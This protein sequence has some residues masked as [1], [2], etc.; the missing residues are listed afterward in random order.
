MN[1]QICD[2]SWK[3]SLGLGMILPNLSWL[4]VGIPTTLKNMS[5]LGWWTS[6]LLN[7][8]IKHDPKHQPVSLRADCKGRCNWHTRGIHGSFKKKV[9]LTSP[10]L[11]PWHVRWVLTSPSPGSLEGSRW[12]GR[13]SAIHVKRVILFGSNAKEM[14][15]SSL[16]SSPY[17]VPY[18][19]MLFPVFLGGS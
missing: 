8:K 9:D 7:G 16:I 3:A 12:D 11:K 19:H 2:S 1:K 17:D 10:E 14:C 15:K 18:F 5:Q 4:V 6:Q 13:V